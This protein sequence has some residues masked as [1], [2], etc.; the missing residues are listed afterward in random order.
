MLRVARDPEAL[1]RVDRAAG[2]KHRFDDPEQQYSVRYLAETL[3]GCLMET[4]QRFRPPHRMSDVDDRLAEV[5]GVDTDDA[6]PDI[7][8]GL[9]VWLD[10]QFVTAASLIETQDALLKVA[11]AF[12]A[13]CDDPRV[14]SA[15]LAHFHES[16]HLD[17]AHVLSGDSG[18][19]AVTQAISRAV[20]DLDDRPAGIEYPS[21][22][23]LAIK[24]W[25]VFDRASI[26]FEGTSR[27]DPHDLTH[28]RAVR[29]V[30]N[31]YSIEIPLTWC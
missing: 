12:D 22:R 31:R 9:R 18:G 19:R 21:R 4:M 13:L 15:R 25:A 27:L 29:D 10:G 3:Y 16:P 14:E 2:P 8:R 28:K 5:T 24:C 11:V 26:D 1:P 30:C 17:L 7:D 20:Y 23:D 6:Q